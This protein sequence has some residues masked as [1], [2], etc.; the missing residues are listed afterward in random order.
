MTNFT[1]DTHL[2]RELGELLVGRDSTALVELIKNSYDAD[3]TEVIVHAQNLNNPE[4][5]II[6]ISD[7][8]SGMTRRQFEEGFLRV[9]S[10]IK[11]DGER[12]SDRLKRRY[13]GA[14]GI[15]R[16]A[17]HKLARLLKILSI[18][19]EAG[20][21]SAVE[22]KIDWD[23][24]ERFE[25]LDQIEG[26]NAIVV[27]HGTA[28]KSGA[29]TTLSLS[30]LRRRWS[31]TERVRFFAE[32]QSFA[33]P[34]FLTGT[35]KKSIIERSLL[36][37]EPLVRSVE[38]I[39]QEFKVSLEGEFAT[40]D[41][42]WQLMEEHAA[43]VIEIRS[44]PGDLTVEYAI[45][46][47]TRTLAVLPDAKSYRTSLKHRTPETGPFFDARIFLRV[48]NLKGNEEQRI[49]TTKSSGVRVF[50]E[51]FR[52]LPYGEPQ[53]DWL[54]LDADYTRRSRTLKTLKD[55]E[56]DGLE[57]VSDPDAALT[58]FP[59]HNYFGGVFLTYDNAP[60]LR[61][62]VNREGFIPEGA[63]Y[64]LVAMVRTGVDL[65]T[66]AHAAASYQKRQARSKARRN[67]S[68]KES[69]EQS[70]LP[71]L[72]SLQRVMEALVEARAHLVATVTTDDGKAPALMEKLGQALKDIQAQVDISQEG[73]SE[74]SLLRVLASVG[75]QMS[76]F[77]HEIRGL[78]GASQAIE[79]A[80]E[81]LTADSILNQNQRQKLKKI[82]QAVGELRRGLER[83]A[84][85]LTD[86]VTP[87]ARRRR[88]RLRLAERFEV[89]RR[90]V[91]HT[92][93]RRGIRIECDIP[94]DLKSP[95]MFPAELTAVFTNL[96]SNAIKAAGQ[97]G[98]IVASGR[99][100]KDGTV[101]VLIQN[102]GVRVELDR[103][104]MWFR[105]F[106]STTSDVDPVLGQ[107]MGLGLSITRRILDDYGASISF[108]KPIDKFATAIEFTFP[109][110]Q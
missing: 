53:N 30:R 90:L 11:D 42:Y 77:V 33:P 97:E 83:E 104:E 12:R 84:S 57:P 107:G 4:E 61:M 102:T 2:F 78:L 66:R 99:H 94:F 35:L 108:V 65:C 51:G 69:S 70:E 105:P 46:P 40:G 16:L 8:G 34:K 19:T 29:G 50:M 93:Q 106:E 72:L 6:V 22:A 58:L 80:L 37:G 3:A 24:I 31:S 26:S 62:L 18:S 48:G 63:Y 20:A 32:V 36:F 13:T 96:L 1:I 86:I 14:K 49:W 27:A 71:R 92:A 21:V 10:R 98:Q 39:G 82:L 74:E 45:A 54:S 60:N 79:R 109:G 59:N 81:D 85:H 89:A 88:S 52:V 25:T 17:A 55:Q 43:W 23:E 9:A 68:S 44:R 67:A 41:D 87:D 95:P 91:A 103:A 28:A 101:H 56:L 75:T 100:E 110:D 38:N 7:N 47:T 64:D 5:G 73:I 76:A 15:G